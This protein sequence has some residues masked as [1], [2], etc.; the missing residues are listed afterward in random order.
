MRREYPHVV[1]VFKN[2][3]FPP[4]ISKGL[5]AGAGRF[6]GP[7]A[8]RAQFQPAGG[9]HG[10]AFSGKYKSLF[11]ANQGTKA[12]RLDALQDAI[13]EVY[14]SIFGPDP[15]E[16]RAERGLLDLHE[17]MGIMIQEVVGTARGKVLP[18]CLRRRGVQQQRVPLVP[19]IRREDG[20]V[21]MVPGLGTRA[22]DRRRRRLSR[23]G[24]AGQ[25]GLRVNVHAGRDGALLARRRWTSSTWRRNASRRCRCRSSSRDVRTTDYP[26]AS[27]ILSIVERDRVRKPDRHRARLRD[28]TRSW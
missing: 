1:Q 5:A 23:A 2:S 25:P 8:D 27:K 24:G 15:I 12:E 13:A 14:A 9:P 10:R 3:R 18:A 6:R 7:A 28:A 4:E 17:E 19:R 16:Y 11:L 21:R 20:L 22:V 26:M